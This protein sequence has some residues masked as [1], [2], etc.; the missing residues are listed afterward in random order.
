[1]ANSKINVVPVL[2]RNAAGDPIVVKSPKKSKGPKKGPKKPKRDYYAHENEIFKDMKMKAKRHQKQDGLSGYITQGPSDLQKLFGELIDPK[3]FEIFKTEGIGDL[4]NGLFSFPTTVSDTVEG[5]QAATNSV[6]SVAD[7][8]STIEDL[9]GGFN[10]ITEAAARFA[11]EGAKIDHVL[12]IEPLYEAIICMVV[13]CWFYQREDV[14][15]KVLTICAAV[16]VFYLASKNPNISVAVV[17]LLTAACSRIGLLRY[18]AANMDDVGASDTYYTAGPT[19]QSNL[20]VAGSLVML[21]ATC[22]NYSVNPDASLFEKFVS[23]SEKTSKNINIGRNTFSSISNIL[24]FFQDL[25]NLIPAMFGSDWRANFTGEYW[26]ELDKQ[27]DEY[28]SLKQAFLDR[29]DLVNV[30]RKVDILLKTVEKTSVKRSSG[31]Y[32]QHRDL[33]N[34]LNQLS[35]ELKGYGAYG[36]AERSEPFVIVVSGKPGVGKSYVS[37]AIQTVF[38]RKILSPA[39]FEDFALGRVGNLVWTPNLVEEFDSA[40]N[41]QPF[42]LCDDLGYSTEA[43]RVTIPKFISWVNQH[44]LQTNQ[45]GLE[46]KGNIMFDSKVILC[47]SNMVD[48]SRADNSLTTPDALCRRLHFCL[49][50]DVKPEWAGVDGQLDIQKAMR[51]SGGDMDSCFWLDFK[52]FNPYNG[53]IIPFDKHMRFADVLT[54]MMDTYDY[55]AQIHDKKTLQSRQFASKLATIR[56]DLCANLANVLSEPEFQ[57]QGLFRCHPACVPCNELCEDDIDTNL[58]PFHEDLARILCQ[59]CNRMVDRAVPSDHYPEGGCVAKDL[60]SFDGSTKKLNLECDYEYA[61]YLR[62]CRSRKTA[63]IKITTLAS[64]IKDTFVHY[65]KMIYERIREVFG[66]SWE[67]ILGAITFIGAAGLLWKFFKKPHEGE[68]MQTQARDDNA[69]QLRRKLINHNIVWACAGTGER[70]GAMLAIGGELLLMNRHT[71]VL[72]KQNNVERVVLKRYSVNKDPPRFDVSGNTFSDPENVH[73]FADSDLVVVRVPKYAAASIV[74]QFADEKLTWTEA[75]TRNVGL[76]FWEL[77]PNGHGESTMLHGTARGFRPI[78]A[79]DLLNNKYMTRDTLEYSF[80]THNGLCCAPVVVDDPKIDAKIVGVHIA[81]SDRSRRG[82]AAVVTRQMLE[83][84][85]NHFKPLIPQVNCNLMIREKVDYDALPEKPVVDAEVIGLCHRKKPNYKTELCRSPLFKKIKDVP[86]VKFPAILNP[87]FINGKLVDP[88]EL[89]IVDYSRGSIEPNLALYRG[90]ELSFLAMLKQS[91]ND[92]GFIDEISFEDAVA[93]NKYKVPNLMPIKRSTSAGFPDGEYFRDKKKSIFGETDDYIFDSDECLFLKEAV[94]EM[95][96]HLKAGPIDVIC[97]VFPKDE[98]RPAEKIKNLKTRLIM[99]ASVS[100]SILTRMIFA[101]YLDWFLEPSNRIL[102]WS[103]VGIDMASEDDLLQYVNYHHAGDPNYRVFA[104]DFSGFDKRLSAWLMESSW[105][106][107]DMY[108]RPYRDEVAMKRAMHLYYSNTHPKMQVNDSLIQWS[109]SNPSG[110]ALTT[111]LNTNAN[112]LATHYAVAYVVLGTD[113]TEASVSKFWQICHKKGY[114]RATTFGDDGVLSVIKGRHDGYDFDKISYSSLSEAYAS[115]GLVYTDEMKSLEFDEG[116]RT[117]YDVTF[118]KRKV[119][120]SE[121]GLVACLDIETIV[122]NIQWRKR[123]D[124]DLESWH[125]KLEL[126]LN[127]LSIHPDDVWDYYYPRLQ[128]AYLNS[129]ENQTFSFEPTKLERMRRW[130]TSSLLLQ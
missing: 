29:E 13:F 46:R 115:L 24:V 130:R 5:F 128:S 7:V 59:C 75:K 108:A 61:A 38:A 93:G 76:A 106:V 44:P 105:K 9:P 122:Q 52:M 91:C 55:R 33:K 101:S 19:V 12:K 100:S 27:K 23:V 54:S 104:G 94:A 111:P 73:Y 63:K 20:S 56:G 72:V 6:R 118:L 127:E 64:W 37:K 112:S 57:T 77:A 114:V 49:Y 45:A 47:T 25:V 81:G 31:L 84:A 109:N 16:Y 15:S 70:I 119:R 4:I 117:I 97:S 43:N 99:S 65:I 60:R 66:K 88:V 51:M 30:S 22:M 82:Y 32:A 58:R 28:L 126:F 68:L 71:Y 35:I 8:L 1:M 48:F 17:G 67:V 79:V 125:D 123:D 92:P 116:E 10:N 80:P 3:D 53:H 85:I 36:Y 113:A 83:D 18:V 95:Y 121:I 102:N 120:R 39:A 69:A 107:F 11:R 89:N 87:K 14:P 129:V 74:T 42:V 21:L 26:A 78:E 62:A 103:A 40:Y 41:N 86:P 2:A 110:W 34:A 124:D 90:C 96:E 98:L 50:V